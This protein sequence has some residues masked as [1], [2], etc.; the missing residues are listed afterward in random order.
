MRYA[1]Y[2]VRNVHNDE[3]T[4][5]LFEPRH[6]EY[7]GVP[8]NSLGLGQLEAHELIHEWNEQPGTDYVFYLTKE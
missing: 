8:Y 2:Y 7:V 4:T 6:Y 3:V 5:Y 1:K